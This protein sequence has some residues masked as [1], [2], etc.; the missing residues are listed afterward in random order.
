[1]PHLLHLDSSADLTGSRSRA[2]TAAFAKAWADR[3]ADHTI[4]YRDLHTDPL[5][6]LS[7]TALHWAPRLR[8]EGE[9]APAEDEARQRMVLDELLAAD[10]L[11][12]GAPM[13]NYSLPSTLK[14]WVDHV[15][16]PGVTTTLDDTPSQPLAGRPAVVVT[17]AGGSYAEGSPTAG[18][19]H[20]T[21]VLRIILGDALGMTVTVVATE[22]TLA[23]R[24]PDL[25]P[26]V[27]HSE[28]LF[29]AALDRATALGATL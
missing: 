12:V 9:T 27:P 10:V 11:L 21:P 8:A 19:D 1:M 2:I 18:W 5:P 25:A 16:V 24:I 4:T 17:S 6:R 29:A 22:L 13:Y 7:A 14:T 20:L 26:Q 15:H 28:A 3:G 23:P